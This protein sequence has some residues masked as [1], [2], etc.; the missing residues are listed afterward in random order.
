MSKGKR[1]SNNKPKLNLKKVFGV[2]I[3]LVIVIAFVFT[4]IKLLNSENT[5]TLKTT[6]YYALYENDKW[7]VIDTSSNVIVEPIYDE[8]IVI[9][10]HGKDVFICTENIDYENETY[11]TKVINAKNQEVLEDYDQVEAIENYDENHNLWYEK[12]VLTYVQDNQYGLINLNG[13]V[14]AEAQFEDIYALKGM[15]N[16]LVTVKEGKLGLMNEKGEEII[17]NAYTEIS[18]L[19]E[20][21]N[22]YIVKNENNQFGIYGK[23]DTKYEEIKPLNDSE[24]FCVKENGKYKVINSEEKELIDQEINTVEQTKDNIIVYTDANKKY[25]VYDLEQNKTIECKYDQIK[26]TSNK[27]F[28][29]KQG[30]SY[31]IIDINENKK[32][33]TDFS[34]IVYYE[35][36]GVYELEPKENITGENKILN[37]NLEEIAQ[38]ILDE[39]NSEK[40]YIRL[41]TENGY[42]YYNLNGDLKESKDILLQNNLFLKKEN[43]KYGY[44][45]KEGNVVVDYIYDDAKEQNE[46]G[47]AAVKK[48]GKWGAIDDQGN[49]VCETSYNLDDNLLIDFIGTYHLGKDINLMYYTNQ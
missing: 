15:E 33:N 11:T 46:F 49:L 27:Y 1:Y 10:D 2:L 21:T 8:I 23:L 43:G 37:N 4:L 30:N 45:D 25:G 18:S 20:D 28:I 31:G 36:A 44:V 47:Y 14:L 6:E 19:G 13:D 24:V 42:Q 12:N 39:V 5:T 34:N 29:V 16:A 41:W 17:P 3:A 26:Y 7:G 35:D 9:P 32:E 38:G 48:D 40:S 22:L